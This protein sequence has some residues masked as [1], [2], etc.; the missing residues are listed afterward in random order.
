MDAGIA[1]VTDD[2][3][4]SGNFAKM[5][6]MENASISILHKIRGR[7]HLI[8]LRR[9]Q[10][11]F[12]DYVHQFNIKCT[13][14]QLMSNLSVGN[15]QKI[16]VSRALMTSCRVLILLEPTRGIDVGAKAQMHHIIHEFAEKGI[17]VIVVSSDL[18]EV[19]QLADRVMVMYNGRSQ[20]FLEGREIDEDHIMLKA[21]GL[22]EKNK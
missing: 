4:N 16:L 12:D 19:I 3:K 9:E 13:A 21:A 10:K 6:A 8:D 17:A 2:R 11:Y 15:Q 14:N 20:G 5:T 1:L 7:S 18:P 22:K